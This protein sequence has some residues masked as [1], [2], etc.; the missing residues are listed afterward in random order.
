MPILQNATSCHH[1]SID[2][3]T[4]YVLPLI[5]MFPAWLNF[6]GKKKKIN[7]K[8]GRTFLVCASYDFGTI[9]ILQ[10]REPKLRESVIVLSF[11]YIL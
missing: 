7:C 1:I 5:A 4:Q 6:F 11:L 9:L 3:S 10:E 2:S 8:K